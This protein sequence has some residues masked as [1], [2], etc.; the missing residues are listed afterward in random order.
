MDIEESMSDDEALGTLG[1][2]VES[3]S[4][5]EM[6]VR[7]DA[8]RGMQLD[9]SGSS[10]SELSVNQDEPKHLSSSDSKKSKPECM[11]PFGL[12]YGD[13]SNMRPQCKPFFEE[14]QPI[15]IRLQQVAFA[16]AR[17]TPRHRN[18]LRPADAP[19]LRVYGSLRCIS[20]THLVPT[21]L[22]RRN[23]LELP[24]CLLFDPECTKQALP[25]REQA[26]VSASFG[27]WLM[28]LPQGWTS[29]APLEAHQVRRLLS[30][31]PLEGMPAS[32]P[33]HGSRWKSISIFS[34]C[35]AL[36]LGLLP[37]ARPMLYCDNCSAAK[38]IL[39][40]RMEDGSL[41][42][43]PVI[44]DVVLVTAAA[45]EALPEKPVVLIAGFPCQDICQAGLQRGLEGDRSCLFFEILRI[46]DE[47]PFLEVIFLEN[48]NAIRS[49]DQ[50]WHV[51]LDAFLGRGFCVRWVTLPA[52]V[53]GCPQKRTRW[54]FLARRGASTCI[55][56]ASA[57]PLD[58]P[59]VSASR[60]CVTCP[61]QRSGLNFNSGRPEPSCWLAPREH[62]YKFLADRLHMLGNAV[63]PQQAALAAQLLSTDW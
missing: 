32:P 52:T 59:G 46:V 62:Y 60:P 8:T 33:Q 19:T 29:T 31:V 36:D 53:V 26:V 63:V 57:L 13:R 56:F 21:V 48:V 7:G 14:F 16:E 18:V 11:P 30:S 54:F 61:A 24:S 28:G 58:G 39:R 23:K 34:G 20:L 10:S 6:S 1:M 15:N 5:G 25:A 45:L 12:C 35:G 4:G 37:W 42:L 9:E 41:P 50:V 40:A 49:M 47:C 43:G 22:T 55:P 44:D 51:L 3:S 27:E 2:Q 38:Q 17:A